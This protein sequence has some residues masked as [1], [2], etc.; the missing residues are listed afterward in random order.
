MI[1]KSDLEGFAVVVGIDEY[2]VDKGAPIFDT[3]FDETA[4][5]CFESFDDG[6]AGEV[7]DGEGHLFAF[8]FKGDF[9]AAGRVLEEFAV[10]GI[11]PE[12]NHFDFVGDVASFAEAVPVLEPLVGLGF[13]SEGD[14]EN[15]SLF[16]GLDLQF[17]AQL[18]KIVGAEGMIIGY[19]SLF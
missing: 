5:G 3:G 13:L 14:E 1:G 8:A 9:S 11:G 12:F 4:T 19:A 7:L 15:V 2:A 18:L 10:F 16:L 17:F 6:G